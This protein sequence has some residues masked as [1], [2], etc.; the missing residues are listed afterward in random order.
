[1]SANS[2]PA[3]PEF[4]PANMTSVSDKPKRYHP[5]LVA[6]HWL[7]AILIFGAFFL[8]QGGENERGRFRPGQGFQP[9]NPPQTFGDDEAPRVFPP[10]G[11]PAQ[12]GSQGVLSAL[13]IHM[14][15]G[16]IVLVLLIIRLIVRWG[17][18][19]PEWASAGNK[20]FDWVGGLTHFGLYLLTFG[21]TI[22]GIILADQRGILARTFGIGSTPTPSS[23]GRGGFSLGFFHGGIWTLLLLLIIL[24][25]G[26]SLYHQFIRK[27][28]LLACMWFGKKNE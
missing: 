1:M 2:V 26:A 15:F 22:T 11:F 19:H 8:V 17:T 21:M 9:G 27:D 3:E 20:F 12:E 10:G 18:K 16:L 7:I 24:H 6:L 14:I 23:F 25:V 4:M 28:N 5:A 13:G